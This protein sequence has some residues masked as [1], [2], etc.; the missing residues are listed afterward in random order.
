MTTKPIKHRNKSNESKHQC[1]VVDWYGMQYPL[2][3]DCLFSSANGAHLA[4]TKQQRIKQIAV[5]KREGFKP[6]VSDL[7]L[8]VPSRNYHG[9]WLEMK[10]EGKTNCSVSD[11]QFDHLQ[12]MRFMGYSAMWC[13]GFNEAKSA[14]KYYMSG[15]SEET[16]EQARK[17]KLYKQQ[18]KETRDNAKRQRRQSK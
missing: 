1:S 10:D 9:L 8:A 6:G 17:Y 16:I 15:V 14:I 4:G 18:A 5:M 7:Q 2:F 3:R 12:L 11:E 13:A